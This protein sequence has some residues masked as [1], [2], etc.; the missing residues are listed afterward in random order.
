VRWKAKWGVNVRL[1]AM[2]ASRRVRRVNEPL[3]HADRQQQRHLIAIAVQLSFHALPMHDG[4][5][6]DPVV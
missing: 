1:L 4:T 5:M 6:L 3:T 2:S